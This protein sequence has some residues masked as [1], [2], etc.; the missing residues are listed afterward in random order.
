M[1]IKTNIYPLYSFS[2]SGCSKYLAQVCLFT[3]SLIQLSHLLTLYLV[4]H[5]L[6]PFSTSGEDPCGMQLYADLFKENH[7]TGKM[8]LLLTENDVRDM[9]VKSKGHVMHLKARQLSTN[10]D[11][12]LFNLG[13]LIFGNKVI[14]SFF[15]GREKLKS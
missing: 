10:N 3:F 14:L 4:D 11:C 7:I 13:S 2:I 12:Y 9:G 8:L 15:F 6:F 1:T 5:W